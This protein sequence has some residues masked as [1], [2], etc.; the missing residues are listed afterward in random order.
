MRA[1]E[2]LERAER[3]A[4]DWLEGERARDRRCAGP[5]PSASHHTVGVR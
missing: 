2:A 5:A 3:A 1:M 4:N